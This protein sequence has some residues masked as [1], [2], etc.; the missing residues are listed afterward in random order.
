[1]PT[2]SANISGAPDPLN[3]DEVERSLGDACD[4]ILDGGPTKG[5]R[6]STIIDCAAGPP[7]VVRAGAIPVGRLMEALD[8]AGIPHALGE[9]A[10]P[11]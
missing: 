10:V 8:A 5:G 7:A 2:T 9:P 4:A 11:G 1:M 6:P 3:A